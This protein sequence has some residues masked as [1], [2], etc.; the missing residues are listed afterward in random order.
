MP[1]EFCRK[2]LALAVIVIVLAATS[3]PALAVDAHANESF[4]RAK[5]AASNWNKEAVKESA[6]LYLTAADEFTKLGDLSSASQSLRRAARMQ[7]VLGLLT[8]AL[9]TTKQAVALNDRLQPPDAI[10][11]LASYARLSGLIDNDQEAASAI[12]QIGSLLSKTDDPASRGFY[13]RSL[14]ER[15]EQ[16]RDFPLAESN[17]EQ[18]VTF[19]RQGDDE[20]ALANTLVALGGARVATGHYLHGLGNADEAKMLFLRSGDPRL[21]N[22][23][24][25]LRG[26]LLNMLGRKQEALE[27]YL[28]AEKAFPVDIDLLERARLLSGIGF[29]YHEMG[30]YELALIRRRSALE[31]YEKERYLLGIEL[32]RSILVEASFKVGNEKEAF[33]YLRLSEEF[34]RQ[35]NTHFGLAA[36]RK[37]IGD[38]FFEKREFDQAVPYYEKALEFFDR[39]KSLFSAAG[40][41]DMLGCV[42]ANKGNK[43]LARKYFDRSLELN[44]R[45]HNRLGVNNTLYNLARLNFSEGNIDEALRFSQASVDGTESVSAELSNTKLRSSHFAT[46]SERFDF[47]VQLLMDAAERSGDG[48]YSIR[49]LQAAERS[50]ARTMLEKLS[51]LDSGQL[52]IADADAETV[53]AEKE[54][55]VAYNAA[56]DRLANLMDQGDSQNAI[57]SAD[58]E[59][60]EI[61]QKIEEVRSAAKEKSPF[62]TAIKTPRSLDL[63]SL[64]QHA[65]ATNS[66]VLEYWLGRDKSYLWIIDGAGTRSVTL[67]GRET[68]AKDVAKFRQALAANE[69]V[70]G[71]TIELFQKRAALAKEEYLTAGKELSRVL[72]GPVS[73]RSGDKNIIV[74]PDGE[75]NSLPFAALPSIETDAPLLES[76]NVVYQPSA[77]TLLLLEK[78]NI[79]P[80]PHQ[81]GLLV[82]SDPV[83]TEDDERLSGI[84]KT[85]SED[86]ASAAAATNFRFVE[87][88]SSLTRL[89]GS[90]REA[91]SI[92]AALGSS[93]DRLDGFSATREAFIN[94]ASGDYGILHIATH[95]KADTDRPEQSGII[96]SRFDR[97]GGRIN[98]MVRLQDIYSMRLRCELVVLSACETAVGKELKG[99]GLLSLN[100]AFLQTG[101]RTVLS[102]LWKVEDDATQILMSAFYEGIAKRGLSPSD[103]LREAQLKLR[104]EPRFNSPFYWAAFTLHGAASD[105]PRLKTA[106]TISTS[107]LIGL[108]LSSLLIAVAVFI[109]IRRKRS[110]SK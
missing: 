34:S 27:E 58:R 64:V 62:Y 20:N 79:Q 35:Y 66:A 28:A 97:D 60:R 98:E 109:G 65:S 104:Q 15:Y 101:S 71:E 73:N 59:I 54:L 50:R 48:S 102:T 18:A 14:G 96:F 37:F 10:K 74:I 110:F 12:E 81:R 33:E 2:S 88:L 87:S 39:S 94:A 85:V 9:K 90:S 31:I 57:D 93:V 45:I 19:L 16:K 46:V 25:T 6:S 52:V 1:H 108:G 44:N 23:A 100:N 67:P 41:N 80:E 22:K 13:H 86:K 24:L 49:A 32:G 21:V 76:N 63:E 38:H 61:E 43:E 51:A 95:A 29:L 40:I 83:F 91:D 36:A 47:H 17:F 106:T 30:E 72:L 4:E 53:K 84:A 105:V 26:N 3:L 11:N 89:R 107:L 7:E 92:S 78:E 82:F 77:Q 42:Y 70:P 75:L 55:L 103:S 68:I 69:P 99:E 56:S 5:N 8:D